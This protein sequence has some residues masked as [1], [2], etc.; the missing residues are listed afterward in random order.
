MVLLTPSVAAS[1]AALRIIITCTGKVSAI[2]RLYDLFILPWLGLVHDLLVWTGRPANYVAK[3]NEHQKFGHLNVEKSGGGGCAAW[4]EEDSFC[5]IRCAPCSCL[6][7]CSSLWHRRSVV[8]IGRFE[9]SSPYLPIGGKP[10]VNSS[11]VRVCR[12]YNVVT[13]DA[14]FRSCRYRSRL[15]RIEE[16]LKNDTIA[17]LRIESTLT[18][19]W[20]CHCESPPSSHYWFRWFPY[21]LNRW[22][23]LE[24]TS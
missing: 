1:P 21:E 12:N 5:C 24:Y 17:F 10:S 2:W 14:T 6:F 7:S 3:K 22:N 23:S 9:N 15:I 20:D 19:M 4:H 18:W 8:S 13:M 16:N 11:W